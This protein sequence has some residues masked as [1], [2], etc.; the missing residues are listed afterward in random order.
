MLNTLR[1]KKVIVG[2]TGGIAAY[3]AAHI[4]RLLVKNGA[5]VK[6]IMTDAAKE[7]ITP[8][9]LSTLSKNPV[10]SGFFDEKDGNWNS[11]V[12]LGLWADALL[13]APATANTMSKMVNG[14]AD[15]LLIATYLAAK[16]PVF[17][18][19]AMDL[20][21]FT[22]PSTTNNLEILKKR[23]NYIIDPVA[24]EL[25]SGLEGK[26]RLDEP[27]NIVRYL[28]DYFVPKNMLGKKILIT[29][30]PTY[31][32]IDLVRYIGNYSSGK[33]GFA[34]AENC[35]RRGAD[36]ILISGPVSLSTPY[37]NIERI[38]VDTTEQMYN[39]V[40]THFENMDGAIMCAA[41]SDFTPVEKLDNKM[42]RGKNNIQLELK[43]TVDIASAVGAIKKP[44]QFVVGFA[45]EAENGEENAIAKMERKNLDFIVLNYLNDPFAGFGVDTNK[46]TILHRNGMVKQY[47]L[48]DKLDVADDIV[49][50]INTLLF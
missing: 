13:I 46:V 33:M 8:L 12:D 5:E 37:K 36:V 19:P 50:E 27:E 34:L 20:H 40:M 16:C 35:A 28:Q 14:A 31:E 6:V 4:V 23:G 10:V 21:M 24:G 44:E 15:N 47:E 48:K 38:N 39:K 25:A 22:H 43:P 42:K 41:V 29:V 32:K 17:I 3:K 18:A 30:G 11:H 9:T 1:D 7:F 49:Q 26:G 45:L 2:V